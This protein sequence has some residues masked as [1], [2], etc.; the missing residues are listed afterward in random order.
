MKRERTREQCKPRK[1]PSKNNQARKFP[2]AY[3][4]WGSGRIWDM[5]VNGFHKHSS[6]YKIPEILRILLYVDTHPEFRE[7]Q[8]SDWRLAGR[9]GLEFSLWRRLDDAGETGIRRRTQGRPAAFMRQSHGIWRDC[10][11][12]GRAMP[13]SQQGRAVYLMQKRTK[14]ASFGSFKIS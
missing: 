9:R 10:R 1:M 4:A 8:A 7:P 12:D 3:G 5:T 13:N 6:C 14:G 2:G 11:G